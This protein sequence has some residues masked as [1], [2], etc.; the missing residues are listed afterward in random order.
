[1][2]LI[3]E[4]KYFEQRYTEG[5]VQLY[6]GLTYKTRDIIKTADFYTLSR[7]LTGQKDDLQ[8]DKPFYNVVNFRVTLAKTATEFDTKDVVATSDVPTEWVQTMLLN[9][10]VNKWMKRT[11]FSRFL[12]KYAYIR[13]K[14]GGVLYK[15]TMQEIDKKQEVVVEV[16]DWRNTYVDGVDIIGSPIIEKHYMSPLDFYNKKGTWEHVD[17]ALELFEEKREK[18]GDDEAPTRLEVWEITGVLSDNAW[19][20]AHDE[21]EMDEDE[22]SLQKHF[23]LVD[24]DKELIMYST[25]PKELGYRYL[26]WE[27]VPGRG[28]GRGIIE[29]SEEGQ[30]W[31]NDLILKQKNTMDL[32][33]KVTVVT[34]ADNVPSNVLEVDD[35]KI[36]KLE[37]GRSMNKLELAPA[38]LG[39][40]Q[41]IVEQWNAQLDKATSTF[42][43]NTGE[44]MPSGTPYSQ[45]ALLN[46]VAQRPFAFRQEEAGIDLEEMLNEWIV[47]H[48]I[49]Q[50]YKGHILASD[51]TDDELTVLDES[52]GNKMAREAAKTLLL[53]GQMFE[54]EDLDTIRSQAIERA[55]KNGT[56]RYVEIPDGFFDGWQGKVTFNMTNEQENKQVVM[57]SLNNIMQTV[58]QTYNPQ[59]GEFSILE[60]PV[61]S[62]LFGVIVDKAGIDGVSPA[63]LGIGGAKKPKPQPQ[64]PMPQAQPAPQVPTPVA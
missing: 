43:A 49:K 18:Y 23:I 26:A 12:N 16:C 4:V 64:M 40:F 25:K 27:E 2:K 54:G 47:P 36:F 55:K 21:E 45:T 5:G 6:E 15:K 52:F 48:I 58:A 31:V 63:T 37:E 28:L 51:F 30:V 29:E 34:D 22:Y 44:T 46:Q 35:G 17:E 38:A 53:S 56:K 33:G 24:D 9:R 50:L 1:M 60:N 13:P 61:L 19:R 59:T 8:R 10:E 41:N 42:D 39:N 20:E 11:R 32:A 7:Y 14:Y 3:D 62:K 57:Q